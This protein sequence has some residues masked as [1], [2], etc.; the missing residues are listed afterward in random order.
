MPIYEYKCRQC[1]H[2][3]EF[4]KKMNTNDKFEVCPACGGKA[5]RIVS[6]SS[7]I[8]KGSGWY[9]TDYKGSSPKKVTPKE[10][11]KQASSTETTTS[12][13]T[14]DKKVANAEKAS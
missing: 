14:S 1:G 13:S 7:F 6:Q 3:S 2:I 11:D 5:V 4:I 8:L 10:S 9:V 12:S